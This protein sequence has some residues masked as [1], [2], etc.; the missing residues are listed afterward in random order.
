MVSETPKKAVLNLTPE[1]IEKNLKSI[2][3]SHK[4]TDDLQSKKKTLLFRCA[5]SGLYFPGNYVE[6]WGRKYGIGLGPNVLSECLETDWNAPCAV[7]ENLRT[8]EQIMFPVKQGGHQVDAYIVPTEQIEAQF[9]D[10]DSFAVVA[11]LDPYIVKRGMIV[12]NKQ[13]ENK[14]GRLKAIMAVNGIRASVL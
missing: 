7:P 14:N 10:F 5:G 8:P 12:R 9:A 13:L 4:L 3:D 1:E 11:K 6:Q 2:T